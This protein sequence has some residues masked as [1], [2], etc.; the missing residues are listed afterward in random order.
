[1]AA[2]LRGTSLQ[3]SQGVRLALL[4]PFRHP[5]AARL[6]PGCLNFVCT[7]PCLHAHATGDFPGLAEARHHLITLVQQPGEALFVPSGWFHTG[8]LPASCLF[9]RCALHC[10]AWPCWS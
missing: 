6:P 5:A 9:A 10:V 3:T 1:M 2:M 8:E 4:L 7:S